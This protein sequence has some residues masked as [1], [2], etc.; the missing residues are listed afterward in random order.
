MVTGWR[1]P[2]GL[3]QGEEGDGTEDD[4]SGDDTESLGLLVLLQS[5]VVVE[6]ELDG[7]RDL[8]DDEVVVGVEPLLHLHSLEIDALVELLTTSTHGC[9]REQACESE[10]GISK[11][12]HRKQE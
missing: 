7:G 1:I 2:S 10:R 6:L 9:A 5:L 12:V 11:G 3:G 4:G 8:G